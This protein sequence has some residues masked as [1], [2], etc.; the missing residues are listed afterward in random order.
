MRT[1]T[2]LVAERSLLSTE[3]EFDGIPS[4]CIA[5]PI[6]NEAAAI[7]LCIERI[8]RFLERVETRTAIIAVDDGS[9]DG[10]FELLSRMQARL[11]QLIV[12]KHETNG[13]Y[14]EANRTLCRLAVEHGFQ[15]AIVMDADGTQDPR[16]IANFFAPM[17]QGIDFIKATRYRLGGGVDGVPWQRYLVSR[18]GNLL[19]RAAMNIP[20]SDFSNGF[21]AIRTDRWREIKSTE[22]A[23]ELLIEECYLA[24]KLGLSFGEVPYLLTVRQETESESK[25]SY[26]WRVYLNY[27]SYVFKR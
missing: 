17:R 9:R 11:P 26:Q 19:A 24:R 6:Y 27:L 21:R 7:E 4:F 10:T 2:A 15:Y 16:Y 22:R 8:A 23:F 12:H 18:V 13:G 3:L 5:L 25:F 1:T 20:L 14:G